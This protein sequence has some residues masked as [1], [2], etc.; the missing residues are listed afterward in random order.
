MS[1]RLYEGGETIRELFL[2]FAYRICFLV[3][4]RGEGLEGGKV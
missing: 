1:P 3:A 2:Y 4:V